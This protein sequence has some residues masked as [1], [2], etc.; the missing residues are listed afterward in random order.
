M[1]ASPEPAVPR[2][3]SS[4]RRAL[5]RAG[6]AL[7]LQPLAAC[8][9]PAAPATEPATPID[10]HDPT[11]H[12]AAIEQQIHGRLGVAVHDTGSDRRIAWRADERFPIC[13]SFK[14]LLAAKVLTRIDENEELPDRPISYGASDLL[15][16]A[17]ATREHVAEGR[18]SIAALCAAAI[19][20]SDNTAANLLLATIGGPDALTQ[21]MRLIGDPSSRLDRIEPD[22]NDVPPGDLRDTTTP[23][24]MLD[25]LHTLLLGD[26]L[27]PGSRAQLMRWLSSNTTGNQRLRAGLPADWKTGDKT[28]TG[29]R[30][31]T[32]D[33][34]ILW[35]PDRAPILITAY[36][37][38]TAAPLVEREAALAAIGKVIADWA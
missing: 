2:D 19:E 36:I 25:N 38:E 22:L 8:A 32:N 13:S 35:P 16:W 10:A 27:S 7:L 18:M 37:A 6:A 15:A 12:F 20:Y 28:G 11:P 31:A 17:P 24:A 23:A 26:A 21:Y 14:L 4:G 29:E 34:A 33:V 1:R 3:C 30:G 9:A 5:L